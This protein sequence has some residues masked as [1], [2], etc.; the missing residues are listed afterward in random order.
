MC[1]TT[2]AFCTQGWA[3]TSLFGSSQIPTPNLD[4]LA[5]NGRLLNQYYTLPLC[6]PSRAALMTGLYPI[7]LGKH[8]PTNARQAPR[9]GHFALVYEVAY[10]PLPKCSATLAFS[11]SLS[12]GVTWLFR[13]LVYPP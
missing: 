3:D 8:A 2:V 7:R 5:A 1:I 11:D 12:S 13:G 9:I 6:S 10:F 4:A